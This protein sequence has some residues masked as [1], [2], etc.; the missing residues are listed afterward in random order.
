[1]VVEVVFLRSCG[2]GSTG[3]LLSAVQ[4]QP[5]KKTS[6]KEKKKTTTNTENT[7]KKK[8]VSQGG[9]RNKKNITKEKNQSI[10]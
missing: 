1:M 4:T 7:K 6:G 9:T 10:I 8:D 3:L 2:M 5:I